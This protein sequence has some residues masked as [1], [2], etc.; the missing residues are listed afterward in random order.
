[1]IDFSFPYEPQIG[2]SY[3]LIAPGHTSNLQEQMEKCRIPT[4][5]I[6]TGLGSGSCSF[7]Q[8]LV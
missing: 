4:V 2:T 6:Y 5:F 8:L 1:M 7:A 3:M